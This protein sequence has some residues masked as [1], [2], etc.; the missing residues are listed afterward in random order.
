M[1]LHTHIPRWGQRVA[2]AAVLSLTVATPA[3]ASG[4]FDV[5]AALAERIAGDRDAPVTIIEYASFT[6]PL[7]AAFHN[8]DD[9]VGLKE[10]YIDTGRVKLI[11]RD[12]A[13]DTVSLRASMVARCAGMAGYFERVG[14]LY[15]SQKTWASAEDPTAAM[16]EI[17]GLDDAMLKTCLASAELRDGL[18]RLRQQATDDGVLFTPS[19]VVNGTLYPGSYSIEEFSEIIDPLVADN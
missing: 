14:A 1:Q 4:P 17:A 19:F 3:G 10:R 16:A 9:Y 11:Y 18:F 7:C 15:Q 8:G 12:F 5:G 6:C 13:L 2:V